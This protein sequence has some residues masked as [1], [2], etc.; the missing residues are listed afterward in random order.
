M[1][2]AVR[3]V[4]PA[5]GIEPRTSDYESGG[6]T[7]YVLPM[8]RLMSHRMQV[9]NPSSQ[10]PLH[11]GDDPAALSHRSS[12]GSQST[13]RAWSPPRAGDLR[14][15]RQALGGL[16]STCSATLLSR[17]STRGTKQGSIA[18]ARRLAKGC[19][20]SVLASLKPRAH[21]C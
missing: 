7:D 18:L 10:Y 20:W 13:S 21:S 1:S 5:L 8:C 17:R 3:P 4:E 2:R 6:E 15:Y 14:G 9:M 16:L 12:S 19:S 11:S